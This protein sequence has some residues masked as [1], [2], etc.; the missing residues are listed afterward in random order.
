MLSPGVVGRRRQMDYATDVG[1][2]ITLDDLQLCCYELA[3][4]LHR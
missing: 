4:N 2:G 1:D 3:D